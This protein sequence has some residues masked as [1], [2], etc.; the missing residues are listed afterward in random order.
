MIVR[1]QFS[2]TLH[3]NAHVLYFA[4]IILVVATLPHTEIYL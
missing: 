1:L 2:F 4:I 3:F